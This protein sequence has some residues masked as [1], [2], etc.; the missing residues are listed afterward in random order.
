MACL[1]Y[2]CTPLLPQLLG[3][4]ERHLRC[5]QWVSGVGVNR[6]VGCEQKISPEETMGNKTDSLGG[7]PPENVHGNPGGGHVKHPGRG[8]PSQFLAK[9]GCSTNSETTAVGPG[10]W[11]P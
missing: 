11:K 8:F 9:D 6:A 2:R 1:D 7:D 4:T 5:G 10:E 3:A